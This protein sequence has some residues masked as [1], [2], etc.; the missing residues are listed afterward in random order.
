MDKSPGKTVLSPDLPRGRKDK[1][2]GE[3]PEKADADTRI[4]EAILETKEKLGHIAASL[5]KI[6]EEL[7]DPNNTEKFIDNFRPDDLLEEKDRLLREVERLNEGL[8]KMIFDTN[9][10]VAEEKDRQKQKIN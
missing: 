3:S 5:K 7:G 4:L 2:A 1:V 9:L 6:D 8:N 10:R